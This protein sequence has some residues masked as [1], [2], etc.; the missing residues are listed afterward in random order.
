MFADKS[1]MH[2]GWKR[3]VI[4]LTRI[5]FDHPRGIVIVPSARLDRSKQRRVIVI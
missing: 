5:Y 1:D 2:L 3:V 4:A